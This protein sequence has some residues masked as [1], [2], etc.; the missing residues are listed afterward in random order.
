MLL[1]FKNNFLG[2]KNNLYEFISSTPEP[3]PFFYSNFEEYI[4]DGVRQATTTSTIRSNITSIRRLIVTQTIII[5]GFT[6]LRIPPSNWSTIN[7]GSLRPT[8]SV[9]TNTDASIDGSTNSKQFYNET[10]ILNP[11]TQAER[12]NLTTQYDTYTMKPTNLSLTTLTPGEYNITLFSTG[13]NFDLAVLNN[14]LFPINTNRKI[15]PSP[16]AATTHFAMQVF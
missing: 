5:E 3:E 7:N 4:I 14:T 15:H 13:A 12:A 9:I 8:L 2:Y 11:P 1:S 16:T 6:F 10:R